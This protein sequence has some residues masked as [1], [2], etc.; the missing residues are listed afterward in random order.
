MPNFVYDSNSD[1]RQISFDPG[2][3]HYLTIM[4]S[5]CTYNGNVFVSDIE[6]LED[7]VQVEFEN[8]TNLEFR[9]VGCSMMRGNTD[10]LTLGI[11]AG[12]YS[13]QTKLSENDALSLRVAVNDAISNI[14]G[15]AVSEVRVE[16]TLKQISTY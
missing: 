7:L 14:S 8:I 13:S 10:S 5:N 4:L 6:S 16:T 1:I 9:G 3:F 15:L 12:Y 11:S 2:E